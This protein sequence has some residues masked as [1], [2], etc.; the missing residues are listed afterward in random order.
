LILA[1]FE[2]G[3]CAGDFI[4]AVLYKNPARSLFEGKKS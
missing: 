1:Y 4:F 3:I 2:L